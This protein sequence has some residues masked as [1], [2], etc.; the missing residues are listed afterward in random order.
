MNKSKQD[1]IKNK[2]INKQ[3]KEM[4]DK[5]KRKHLKIIIPKITKIKSA[6]QGYAASYEIEIVSGT[7][8]IIQL[9]KTRKTIKKHKNKQK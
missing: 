9:N 1:T 3:L 7:S 5:V 6:F 4:E 8:P 2:I